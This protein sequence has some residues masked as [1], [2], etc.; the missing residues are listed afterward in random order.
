MSVLLSEPLFS[1]IPFVYEE[2]LSW[3]YETLLLTFMR[4]VFCNNLNN[5]LP[6]YFIPFP[7]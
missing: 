3:M 6:P 7:V 5:L 4:E 1:S 2:S